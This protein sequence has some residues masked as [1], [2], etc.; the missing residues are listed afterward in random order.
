MGQ[1][2]VAPPLTPVLRRQ[3]QGDLI[4]RPAWSTQRNHVLKNQKEKKINETIIKQNK[5]KS[6]KMM[7]TITLNFYM[8]SDI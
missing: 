6:K 4:L 2:V 7:K 8:N 3:R 5:K 1:A